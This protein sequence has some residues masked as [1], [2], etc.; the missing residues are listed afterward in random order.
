MQ[1]PNVSEHARHDVTL[2]AGHAAGDL[3]DTGRS[4]AGALLAACEECSELR[5]DLVAT[6]S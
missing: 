5:R 4:R 2:I 1:H 3:A 6:P